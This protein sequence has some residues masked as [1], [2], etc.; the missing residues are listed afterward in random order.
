[1][2]TTAACFL[3]ISFCFRMSI[4]AQGSLTPPAA[5]VP[6]MKSLDQIASTGIAINST[7]TAGNGSNQFVISQPGSYYI[8][9]NING[10]SGKNCLSINVSDVT[11]DLNGFVLN[12]NGVTG[13]SGIN[14]PNTVS[15][16]TIRNG[17]LRGWTVNGISAANGSNCLFENIRSF[18][19]GTDS[20]GAGIVTGDSCVIRSCLAMNGSMTGFRVGNS[21]SIEQCTAKSV[22]RGYE[23]DSGCVISRCLAAANAGGITI[24][25]ISASSGSLVT[26][27][28]VLG[29]TGDGMSVVDGTVVNCTASAFI[30]GTGINTSSASVIN[31]TANNNQTGIDG[32]L[33]SRVTGCLVSSNSDVGIRA[34]DSVHIVGN[35][36]SQNG[37]AVAGA[38]SGA[39]TVS[40]TENLIDG[41][42]MTDNHRGIT[43]AL[44]QNTITRNFSRGN[45]ANAYPSTAGN[46]L[47]PLG[48]VSTANSPWANIN[49]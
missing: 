36:C 45:G 8:R 14:L 47:G 26:E 19:N 34:S 17:V 7:N 31:C 13:T 44:G 10:V 25:G 22:Q 2:K 40:G 38:T 9:G 20:N 4:L 15:N 48:S 24:S 35:T 3:L 37:N 39:I 21:C 5:P 46:D 41:N 49:D 29:G 23:A 11:V 18:S 42:F 6:T 27:C 1:M 32:G 43:T 12:A 33:Q 16:I 30:D 28:A